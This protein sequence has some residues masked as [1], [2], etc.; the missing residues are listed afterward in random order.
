MKLLI[1]FLIFL[2]SSGVAQNTSTSLKTFGV[3]SAFSS[4]L[5]IKKTC[6][7]SNCD[8]NCEPGFIPVQ[9][10]G[11]KEHLLDDTHC[12]KH[13]LSVFCCP[14]DLPQP[15]CSWKGH[16]KSGRCE[17]GCGKGEVEVGT[18]GAGC[19]FRHQTACCSLGPAVEAYGQ[20]MWHGESPICRDKN[21]HRQSCSKEYPVFMFAASLGFGGDKK[22]DSGK[23]VSSAQYTRF[24]QMMNIYRR[25]KLLLQRSASGAV[26]QLQ[27]VRERDSFLSPEYVRTFM[28]IREYQTCNSRRKLQK[29]RISILLFRSSSSVVSTFASQRAGYR[30]KVPRSC[31]NVSS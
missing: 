29:R 1:S 18:L 10:Q 16:K 14:Q 21:P 15:L 13:G 25:E 20:C 19:R 5:D 8:S 17:P 23:G 27:V 22:C 7:W 2:V 28:S 31:N 26:S 4:T 11:Y 3:D 6:R 24:W 9:R 30:S 12:G